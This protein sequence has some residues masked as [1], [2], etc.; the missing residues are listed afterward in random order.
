MSVSSSATV[1]L[2]HISSC[3]EG[4]IPATICS[5]DREGTP[6][7]TYLSLVHR[8]DEDHVG[9]SYQFFN[10]T[11][12]NVL[13][14]PWV[15]VIVTAPQTFEQFRLD[16]RYERTDTEGAAFDRMK[17][18]LDAVASQTGMS[19]VFRLR[20]M[21][22]YRVLDCRLLNSEVRTESISKIGY[23]PELEA[24]TEGLAAC[25]DLDSLLDAAL[26]SL[27][28]LFGYEHSFV[29]VPD[30]EGNRLYTL[31][32]HGYQQSG[33]GSE[34]WLGE[35]I[36][37]IAA[38]RR[39]VVRTTNMTVD[40][41]VLRAVRS[42]VERRGEGEKLE[43]EIALPG[44]ADAVSQMA[45]PLIAHNELLGVLCLQSPMVGRFLSD[46][47][48]V[49]QIVARHL[50]ASMTMLGRPDPPE[51]QAAPT[52][53]VP[54]QPA[55]TCVI[56]HYREDDSILIDNDYLIKGIAGRIFWKL[57]RD[58]SRTGRADFT[59]KEIRRDASLQLPDFKDNLEARLI[60]LRRRLQDHCSFLRIVQAGRG[61][62]H[63]EVRRR[64]TLEEHS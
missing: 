4:V 16:L 49:M 1:P 13:E 47:E 57:V 27:S 7:L 3:F 39:T 45:V 54:V 61:Q 21:D 62:F 11:R 30:E 51:G 9:L 25:S 44:L 59:N 18:R 50:A 2:D 41:L 40:R 19:Q 42:G 15:Q 46:D 38:E 58:Y 43:G 52:R 31:A 53:S 26:D 32:S 35:G 48:R 12:K 36:L 22:V 17:T 56:K 10:K 5:C 24:F 60:L 8:L 29:M 63:L 20:G 55:G 6:N 37:G 64:L 33:V 28:A 23:L 14:N 34:V